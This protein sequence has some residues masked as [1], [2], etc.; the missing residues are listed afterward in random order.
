MPAITSISQKHTS[1]KE[2]IRDPTHVH[3]Q[4]GGR[5]QPSDSVGQ[6]FALKERC[7]KD[8]LQGADLGKTA[9][10][11]SDTQIPHSQAQHR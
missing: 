3:T 8:T 5:E 6:R 10:I 4:H 11:G 7:V 2:N 1:A 9:S